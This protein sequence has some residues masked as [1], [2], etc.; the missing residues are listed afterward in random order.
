MTEKEFEK[1]FLVTL[2][3][4]VYIR[5]YLRKTMKGKGVLQINYYFDTPD[6]TLYDKHETLR[7][8][9]VGFQLSL[10]YKFNR[11]N[12]NGIWISDEYSRDIFKIPSKI[13]L[14]DNEAGFVG[15]LVTEREAFSD[16]KRTI[17]LDKSFYSGIVDYEIEIEL[18][19]PQKECEKKYETASYSTNVLGKYER[20]VKSVQNQTHSDSNNL[21]YLR[22]T[23]S[24][25]KSL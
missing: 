20:F 1:K 22:F 18:K 12:K 9:Q 10:Q 2:P 7:I 4:F 23:K 14:D 16:S 17:C 21:A 5:N 3:E 25:Q 13:K 19:N 24:S 8:R 11:R 6:F 15:V